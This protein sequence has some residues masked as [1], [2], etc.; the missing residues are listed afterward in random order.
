MTQYLATPGPLR[1]VF[2]ALMAV[3]WHRPYQKGF[4]PTG[5]FVRIQDRDD[6]KRLDTA[7][8]ALHL[9]GQYG[10]IKGEWSGETF[11]CYITGLYKLQD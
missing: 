6:R 7:F 10:F 8:Q 11:V 9:S 3:L 4:S 2:D 5:F 1:D